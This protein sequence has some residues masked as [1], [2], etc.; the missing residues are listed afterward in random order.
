[1]VATRGR[2]LLTDSMCAYSEINCSHFN[3][4]NPSAS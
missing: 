3:W 2:I 1:M 4:K